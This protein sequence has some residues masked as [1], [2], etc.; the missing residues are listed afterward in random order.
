MTERLPPLADLVAKHGLAG[1]EETSFPHTG[2]SGAALTRLVREDGASFVIKRMSVDRDWIMRA[3]DD[4]DCREAAFAA[5]Q[6]DLG[7][8][9]AAPSIGAAIDGDGYAVLMRDITPD[10]LPQTTISRTQLDRIIGAMAALHR[11]PVPAGSSMP[12]CDLSRRL[13]LL[14]PAGAAIARS[15]GAPVAGD[16]VEGWRLIDEHAPPSVRDL[17]H[18]LFVD[19]SPLLR[20]LSALPPALLHGD[21]KLDNIGIDPGGQVWLIDWAMTLVA[22]PAVELGWF[23]AINS[24]RLPAS[25]DEVMRSY[26]DAARMPVDLRERHAALTV[27]CGL[28]LRGWRKA[29]DADGGEPAELAWWCERAD[30]ARRS[31]G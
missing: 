11:L 16:L 7:P 10:L 25:L 12:W 22:P 3:T 23:L 6:V 14:T 29:L 20:A 26:A 5:A 28:L 27:L 19:P 9:V 30:A 8:H 31:L 1:A 18:A 24:R 21:L 17:I 13:T 2:F 4:V 15:Y